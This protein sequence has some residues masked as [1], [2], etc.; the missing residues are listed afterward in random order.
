VKSL[1]FI[2]FQMIQRSLVE[3]ELHPRNVELTT[4]LARYATSC[5]RGWR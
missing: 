1:G 3:I 5:C 2:K 4:L